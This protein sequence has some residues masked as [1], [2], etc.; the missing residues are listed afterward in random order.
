MGGPPVP[1]ED[2]APR[3]RLRFAFTPLLTRLVRAYRPLSMFFWAVSIACVAAL[4]WPGQRIGLETDLTIMH[5]RPNP[6]LDTQA[7]IAKRFGSAPGSL[8]VFLEAKNPHDVVCLAHDV[9]RRL[10][11]PAARA[12]GVSGTLGLATFLPDPRLAEARTAGFPDREVERVIGDFNAV[13]SESSFNPGSKAVRDYAAFLRTLLTQSAPPTVVDLLKYDRLATAVLPRDAVRAGPSAQPTES[14]MVVS[15][16]KAL[17]E[18]TDRA[19]SVNAIRGALSDLPG[20]TLAGIDVV[21]HDVE[22]TIHRDLPVILFVGCGAVVLY[23]LVHYRSVRA[24]YHVVLPTAFSL[25]VLLAI[26]RLTGQRLNMI[27]LVAAPLLIGINIDYGIFLVSL[28]RAAKER[29][30]PAGE[31]IAEIGTSCHAVIVCAMT[32][33]LGFGSL[34][35]TSIP[36]VRSLGIAV[37][38]G[39]TSCLLATLFYLAPL[40]VRSVA[41]SEVT[42]ET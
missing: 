25:A 37:S 31:L 13:I 39:V 8:I 20:A 15:L 36:A 22:G 35:F 27:N 3:A 18:R 26:M 23:L 9:E 6:P 24:M 1:Q 42:Q 32:T 40:L 41:R 5:P 2:D 21:A 34:I 12:A 14:I 33:L 38:I 7:T 11:T 19:A 17:G 28:A 29:R 10:D 30:A 4:L 16:N